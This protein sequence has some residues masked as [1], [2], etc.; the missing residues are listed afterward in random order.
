VRAVRTTAGELQCDALIVAVG[1]SARDTWAWLARDGVVFEA[2][3][4]QLGVRIEHPQALVTAGRYGTGPEARMLGPAAY[5]LRAPAP[6]GG[7]GAHSFC[8][9]PGGRIVASVSEPG[10]LCTNGMSNSKHSSRY[11]N[12]AVVTTLGPASFAEHGAG[13]FAGVALQRAL[14]ARFFAAGGGTYAAPAQRAP[15]VLAGR[16]ASGDFSTSYGFGV[17]PGRIDALLPQAVR[18]ALRGALAAFDRQLPGFGGPEGVLVGVETRSSGPVRA[19][20]DGET[21]CAAGFANL[22][23]I[24]EGAG[25]AGGITS[26]AIDGAHAGQHAARALTAPR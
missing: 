23:P 22:Y 12:A 18:D 25:H 15:A 4:F 1:H 14:E 7:L 17:V 19:P 3:P 26:A 9:C 6:L 10:G 5:N 8:M 16:E 21:R 2:K 11:A 20:R 13:P 24:G